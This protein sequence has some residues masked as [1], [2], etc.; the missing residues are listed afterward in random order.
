[1]K[2]TQSTLPIRTIRNKT[3]IL[4]S[5]TFCSILGISSLNFGLKSPEEQQAIVFEYQR[6]L[7]SLDFPLQICI[8]S[9]LVNID[10]YLTTLQQH[11]RKQQN[12]LLQVQTQAYI[13]FIQ[14]TVMNTNL[15][16]TDF[17]VVVPFT[18]LDLKSSS[19]G[20][21][22][23]LYHIF[24]LGGLFKSTS[25]TYKNDPVMMEGLQQRTS[26][27]SAGLH[28]VGLRAKTL[29]TVELLA[30]YWSLYNEDSLQKNSFIYSFMAT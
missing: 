25:T 15:V 19:G 20:A 7:N 12:E 3:V 11:L 8:T 16:S 21:T 30:L 28:R 2:S 29:S 5:G 14:E 1:M 4:Q 18:P 22:K 6:F 24:T 23:R 9:R 27:V 13:Q 10:K 26:Y 17:Y